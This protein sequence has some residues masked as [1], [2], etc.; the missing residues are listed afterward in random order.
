MPGAFIGTF[1]SVLF[2]AALG[3]TAFK[4]TG[5]NDPAA[6]IG[7]PLGTSMCMGFGTSTVLQLILGNLFGARSFI[8]LGSVL[9]LLCQAYQERRPE[10][11]SH[12]RDTTNRARDLFSSMAGGH[13]IRRG[14]DTVRVDVRE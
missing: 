11:A 13:S 12:F 6:F 14:D 1:T 4:L 10:L 2:S 5:M 8:W 3:A 9:A 7:S